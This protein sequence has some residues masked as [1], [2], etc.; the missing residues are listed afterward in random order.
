MQYSDRVVDVPA[1]A[2]QHL[3]GKPGASQG[4]PLRVAPLY[5][6]ILVKIITSS[7]ALSLLLAPHHDICTVDAM[8]WM[9]APTL[10]L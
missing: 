7:G 6:A 8:A 2:V 9:G 5:R 10:T 3:T 4:S 1:V